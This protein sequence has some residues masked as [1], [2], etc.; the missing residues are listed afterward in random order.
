[1]N[2]SNVSRVPSLSTAFSSTLSKREEDFL[3]LLSYYRK[4]GNKSFFSQEYLA[5]RYGVSVRTISNMIANLKRRGLIM[6]YHRFLTTS[7]YELTSVYYAALSA[8]DYVLDKGIKIF[9]SFSLSLLVSTYLKVCVHR[10]ERERDSISL[11][12]FPVNNLS[13]K[14]SYKTSMEEYVVSPV[15]EKVAEELSLA[16]SDKVKLVG[17][18]DAAL[19]HALVEIKENRRDV[20]N[21][22]DTLF[23]LARAHSDIYGLKI[24]WDAYRDRN[25]YLKALNPKKEPER[26]LG[27]EPVRKFKGPVTV[28]KEVVAKD[29]VENYINFQRDLDA[30]KYG[31]YFT[32]NIYPTP[33]EEEFRTYFSKL[34][35]F[36]AE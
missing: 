27:A 24:D 10:K 23:K 34:N 22:P 36:G 19:Q 8:V 18:C 2:V 28:V 1:M 26:E 35:P 14:E 16:N 15:L 13:K 11:S 33:T 7:V 5:K 12:L 4:L 17:F 9:K 25:K 30:G 21:V 6:V 31:I 20:R 3:E 32:K 29:P